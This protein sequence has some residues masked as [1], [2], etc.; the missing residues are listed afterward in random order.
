MLAAEQRLQ[1]IAGLNASSNKNFSP[2]KY[3]P[4]LY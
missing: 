2:V 1:K 4:L 3:L